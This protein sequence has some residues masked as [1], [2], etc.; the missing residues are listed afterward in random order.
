MIIKEVRTWNTSRNVLTRSMA[1]LYVHIPCSS[2]EVHKNLGFVNTYI[3]Y[4][5]TRLFSIGIAHNT[6]YN[7]T[8][9]LEGNGPP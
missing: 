1:K 4:P 9:W 5:K 7:M 3:F 8:I 2:N 6:C